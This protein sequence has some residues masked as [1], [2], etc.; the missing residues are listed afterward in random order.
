L[1]KTPS[2]LEIDAEVVLMVVDQDHY[3]DTMLPPAKAKPKS[4]PKA[5]PSAKKS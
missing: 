4:T 3:K 1:L 5:K 2:V